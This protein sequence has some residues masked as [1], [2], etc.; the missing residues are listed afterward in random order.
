MYYEENRSLEEEDMG[1]ESPIYHINIYDNFFLIAIGKERKLIQKRNTYYF[2]VYLMN[3]MFVQA[4]IGAFQYE[5]SKDNAKDRIKPFLDKAGDLDLIRLGDLVLYSFANYDY[6][7]DITT[8]I[9]PVVLKELEAKYISE[10]VVLDEGEE[11]PT[12]REKK[13][14]ELSADEIHQS[15]TSKKTAAVLKDGLFTIDKS[16]KKV[17]LLSEETKDQADKLK[18]DYVERPKSKWIEKYMGNNNYDIYETLAQGDCFFDTI[19][20]AF[21]QIGY[22]TTIAKLRAILAQ[23][24]TEPMFMEYRDLYT[25]TI[26][27]IENTE[28]ELRRLSQENK[29]LKQRYEA[30]PKKNISERAQVK[31]AANA[32]K[33]QHEDLKQKQIQNRDF[34]REFDFMK[35]ITTM[36]KFREVIQT[37]DYW[38]DIWAINTLE[39]E[40]NI[41]MCIFSESEYNENDEN[42]VI[43]CSFNSNEDD[44][45]FEPDFYIMT[46]YSGKHYRLITYKTKRIFKFSE[47]PYDVKTMVVIKCLERNSGVFSKIP[48]F[49]RFKSR[50]GINDDQEEPEEEMDIGELSNIDETVVFSFYNKSSDAPA[51]G[52]GANEKLPANKRREYTDL[53]LPKNK[54]WRKKLDDDWSTI[55]TIDGKK[56]K[57]VEHYYQAAKFKKHNPQF[58]NRFSLD[59]KSNEFANDVE[60][61]K[62]AGSQKGILKK[63][64][65]EIPLRPAEITI[66][67]DFYGNRRFQERET[68]LYAKFSQ[69]PDLR[70]VLLATKNSILK[71]FVVK[72]GATPDVLL[73]KVRA[74]IQRE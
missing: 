8:T 22:E 39:R 47:I 30:I 49:I 71:Q 65:K 62:I 13:P 74:K 63:G 45:E 15:V 5:S 23:N 33:Q 32:I 34:L 20:V 7:Q 54:E 51:P 9:S 43:Q 18:E 37:T 68:A 14:F 4:Q 73:M 60:L 56:W 44:R 28:R 16:N 3:K 59:D 10:K 35:G 21:E 46:T 69:N 61:A 58:Y 26:T 17:T 66:D 52:K 55:I 25:G 53:E 42:N 6:F 12:G 67:A 38:A 29:N 50:L 24:A 11:V 57:T 40:L 48:D 70:D 2:P 19:R 27:E 1:Y 64:K 31:E 41:K 72:E 36:D